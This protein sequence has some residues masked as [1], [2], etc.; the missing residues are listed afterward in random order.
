MQIPSCR[1]TAAWPELNTADWLEFTT[2]EMH[3]TEKNKGVK[4]NFR[5]SSSDNLRAA[6]AFS[7]QKKKKNQIIY[8]NK[9]PSYSD[10]E[11]HNLD[12]IFFVEKI[13]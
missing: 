1:H 2:E 4:V 3:Q 13:L 12:F 5:Y 11:N 7:L 6:A 8:S 10:I 9:R